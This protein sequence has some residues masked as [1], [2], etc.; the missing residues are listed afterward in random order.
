MNQMMCFLAFNDPFDRIMIVQA[1]DEGMQFITHDGL[2]E[3][4]N[5]SHVIKV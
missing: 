2:L 4:Y 1:K 3:D 5:E